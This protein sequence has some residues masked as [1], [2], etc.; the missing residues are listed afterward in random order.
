MKLSKQQLKRII[1][2]VTWNG[3]SPSKDAIGNVWMF[4]EELKDHGITTGLQNIR[5]EIEEGRASELP[6]PPVYTPEEM[7]ETIHILMALIELCE[8]YV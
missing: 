6:G 4:G 7:T 1:R 2:E 8:E 5:Y 3:A